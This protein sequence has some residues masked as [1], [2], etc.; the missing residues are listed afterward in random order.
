MRWMVVVNTRIPGRRAAA[1]QTVRTAR[2]LGADGSR[3]TILTPLRWP[4]ARSHREGAIDPAPSRVIRIPCLDGIDW[5]PRRLRSLPA[6]LQEASFGLA[7][8]LAASWSRGHTVLCR[9]IEAG[10]VLAWTGHPS[11]ILEIH[12]IPAGSVRRGLLKAAALG[13]RAVVAISEGLAADL[14]GL[15]ISDVSVVPDAF[16]AGGFQSL[17]DRAEARR[18][19]GPDDGRPLIVYAGHLFDWKGAD[20]LGEASGLLGTAVHV[21]ILGGLEEDVERLRAQA[22][23]HGWPCEVYGHADPGSI[24]VHLRAADV[25][26]LPNRAG[27]RISTHHTSPL[28]A[29]EYAAAGVPVVASDLPALR[30]ALGSDGALFVTPGDAEALAQGIRSAVADRDGSAGRAAA[31]A[32]RCDGRTYEA[33]A[34]ALAAC[35][36]GRSAA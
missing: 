13:A 4:D 34:L 18:S 6:R 28:K 25:A 8:G 11:W 23:Q 21:R 26:V 29:F 12:R 30:E 10:A 14:E 32:R 31:A 17:P 36:G 20:V 5:F 2:A 33:R 16:D 19:V 9:E 22:L 1:L 3:V 7:A 27:P 15:G 24:P 35:V